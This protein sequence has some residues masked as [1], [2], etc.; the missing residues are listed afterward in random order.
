M[1]SIHC[2]LVLRKGSRKF[3][4]PGA[5]GSNREVFNIIY[6]SGERRD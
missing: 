3:I 6:A 2:H 5:V 4:T 1:G